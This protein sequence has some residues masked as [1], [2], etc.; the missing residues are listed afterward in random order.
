MPDS[1]LEQIAMHSVK[2]AKP[3]YEPRPIEVPVVDMSLPENALQAIWHAVAHPPVRR[4]EKQ[5]LR[6]QHH[7]Q[8]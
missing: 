7:E 2:A 6:K 1:R 5:T 8:H 3:L 4:I